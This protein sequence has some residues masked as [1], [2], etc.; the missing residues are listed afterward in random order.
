M[1]RIG[2][3]LGNRILTLFMLVGAEIFLVAPQIHTTDPCPALL[4]PQ[5][6][7]FAAAVTALATAKQPASTPEAENA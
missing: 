3:V 2:V 4:V 1:I 7:I 6:L 5:S